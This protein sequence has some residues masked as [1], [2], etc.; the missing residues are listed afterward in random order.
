MFG[1]SLRDRRLRACVA[2]AVLAIPLV[3]A[4]PATATPLAPVSDSLARLLSTSGQQTV[5]VHGTSATAADTAARAAGLTPVT[6]FR[7]IGVVVAKGSAAQVQAV[8]AKSGVTYVEANDPIRLFA[9]SSGTVATRSLA[10]QQTLTGANGRKLDGSGVSVAIIDSGI[11]PTHPAFKGDDGK[12][13]VA[14]SLK[15]VCLDESSTGTGCIVDTTNSVDTDLLAVGGHGTHVSGIAAGRPY[16]LGD[17]TTV[18][19]SA[20]GA[21][22]VSISIGAVIVIVG[23]DAAL[24]WVLENHRA[25][26]GASV[27]AS[28]CPPIKAINNSYGPIGG[29]EFDAN[30][31]TVKLQRQLAAEGVMTVWANG[32]DGGDGSESLSNPPGQDPT[33]GVVSVASYNDQGTGSRAGT[34]S[35]Y[36]SRGAQADPS[37]W[38]DISAPGENIASACR[39]YLPICATGL[40]PLNGPGLLDLGTYNVIS[41]T[42]MAAPQITGIIAQLFQA[43]PTATPAEIEDVLKRTALKYTDGSGYQT[44]NGYSTSF[45]KGTGLVDVVA[46]ATALGAH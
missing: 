17:G 44:V 7:K 29:G 2:A 31:A 14:R 42:S 30:S 39:L 19:G 4:V 26:C 10:A 37:T 38:P 43:K 35:D 18:G 23:A 16:T 1:R 12:T 41:G 32:N 33:P 11:D 21:K 40:T 34:V 20:P 15:G 45:D 3:A 46:A 24:N 5:L 25:P 36:S 28:T 13:R 6:T 22:I 8:R 27:P 9:H